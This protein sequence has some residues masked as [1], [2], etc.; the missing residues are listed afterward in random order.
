MEYMKLIKLLY[1]ADRRSLIETG[2]PI[3]GDQFFSLPQGPVLSQTLDLVKRMQHSPGANWPQY[4]TAPKHYCVSSSSCLEDQELSEYECELL[5][6]VFDEF[7]HYSQWA[8]VEL[9]H[10]LPEWVDPG[11]SS[12][13]I[14][15]SDILRNEGV[16]EDEISAVQRQ[17]RA[18]ATSGLAFGK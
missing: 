15:P 18:V 13:M 1:L 17:A 8:L 14:D 2:Y 5:D 16:S 11:G 10:E 3:T 6:G 4:V 12:Q 7:G 9:T